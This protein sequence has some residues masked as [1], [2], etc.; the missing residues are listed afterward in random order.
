S[1]WFL[2]SSAFSTHSTV[3]E[4]TYNWWSH[5][6]SFSLVLSQLIQQ[7]FPRKVSESFFSYVLRAIIFA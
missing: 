3:R 4:E 2:L 1:P 5:G 6:G 7:S